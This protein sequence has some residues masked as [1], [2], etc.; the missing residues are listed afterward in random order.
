M[1]PNPTPDTIE[2]HPA[3][4]FDGVNDVRDQTIYRWNVEGSINDTS[5]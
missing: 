1:L 3:K 2:P 4:V 5:P